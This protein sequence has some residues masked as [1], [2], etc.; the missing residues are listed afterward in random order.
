M[1][2]FNKIS[3]VIAAT[4]TLTACSTTPD[5]PFG[6]SGD[7]CEEITVKIYLPPVVSDLSYSK[8]DGLRDQ[9]IIQGGFQYT[10]SLSGQEIVRD[11]SGSA[12]AFSRQSFPLQPVL[13]ASLPEIQSVLFEFDRADLAAS[14]T[15]KLDSFLQRIR[16]ENL[17]H[18]SIEGHTD[19]KGSNSYN[20]QLSAK[21]ARS[22]RNYLIQHGVDASKI[23]A[24]GL[25]EGSPSES[26]RTAEG[27]AKNRR[28][29]L[30]P[31]T[32]K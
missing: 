8:I 6:M 13:E 3:T 19:S 11:K 21:R 30:I 5:C 25:G 23:S 32:E 2:S 1:K 28:A 17:M 31:I 9:A 7:R 16:P 24:K 29:E 26:N 15:Q 10:L 20:K 14:E 27:R 4:F 18:V 12:T 22:V